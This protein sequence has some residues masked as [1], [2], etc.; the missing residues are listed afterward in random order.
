MEWNWLGSILYG[1][2]AGAFAFLPISADTHG[3]LGSQ[4]MGLPGVPAGLSLGV[5]LGGVLAVLVSFYGYMGRLRREYRISAIVPRRR[6]RQPDAA[7]L[8]ELRLLKVAVV[9]AMLGCIL[10]PML[11]GLVALRWAMALIT[12]FN[13]FIVLLPQYT[14]T[15]NKD[16]RSLSGLDALLIGLS[17]VVGAIPGMSRVG[18]MTTVGSLR[19]ADKTFALNFTYLL[20]LPVLA[21][22]ALGDI[23]LLISGSG[24]GV[25]FLGGLLAF[26]SAFGTGLAGIR[27]MQFL[28]VRVGYSAFAY[29]GWGLSMMIFILYLI[30]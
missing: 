29:Y 1:I 18:V 3:V 9:P 19:G 12:A 17:G 28:A 8:M 20:S 15:A 26:L 30:G 13:A 23:W 11:R 7:S 16:S 22:L 14:R 25:G 2:F 6:K 5:H 27:F 10:A 21:G 4:L 24:T